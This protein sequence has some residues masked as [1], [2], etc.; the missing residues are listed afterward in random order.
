MGNLTF[1]ARQSR[2]V[3]WSRRVWSSHDK[4]AAYATQ[5]IFLTRIDTFEVNY[6][7]WVLQWRLRWRLQ[8]EGPIYRCALYRQASQLWLDRCWHQF[9]FYTPSPHGTIPHY[10]QLTAASESS[11]YYH[12]PFNQAVQILSEL[13][14]P[15]LKFF[16]LAHKH[17]LE[18]L[19]A[20]WSIQFPGRWRLYVLHR[21]LNLSLK[22]LS[23]E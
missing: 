16:I 19:G 5:K 23:N 2:L 21:E 10:W 17:Q 8:G 20:S 22:Q 13:V 4:L 9:V 18:S 14:A 12:Q 3:T 6:T 11:Y 7:T 1:Q 15:P